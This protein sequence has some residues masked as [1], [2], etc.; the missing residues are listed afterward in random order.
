MII[1][2]DLR[3]ENFGRRT[4]IDIG[5]VGSVKDTVQAIL[6]MLKDQQN[7]QHLDSSRDHYVQAR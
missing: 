6:P 3:G 7:T 5:L 1:Q 4:P 2:V